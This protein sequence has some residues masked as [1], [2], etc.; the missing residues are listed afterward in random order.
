M[1]FSGDGWGKSA[2]AMGYAMRSAGRGWPT[3]VVQFVKGAAWNAAES[4]V[5]ALAV[6][7]WPVFTPELSWGSRDPKLLCERAWAEATSALESEKPG[8]VVLD[9]ITHA[10]EHRWMAAED[11]AAAIRGRNPLTSVIMTGRS[12]PEE[13]SEVADTVTG[14]ELV[15]HEHR[16]GIL[17]P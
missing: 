6:I 16:T 15:K 5:G 4:S 3:T 7:H 17:A 10:V 2:A 12:A 1:L 14:F 13:L 11:I 9:E 8:L